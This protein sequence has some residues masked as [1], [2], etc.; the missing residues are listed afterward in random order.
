VGKIVSSKCP[1]CGATCEYDEKVTQWYCPHC[2]N[3]LVYVP[4]KSE[5]VEIKRDETEIQ[6]SKHNLL[7]NLIEYGFILLLLILAIIVAFIRS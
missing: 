4:D 1:N 7:N 3:R 2:G 5:H 6:K